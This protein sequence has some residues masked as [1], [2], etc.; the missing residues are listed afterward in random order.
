MSNGVNWPTDWR[1]SARTLQDTLQVE[2]ETISV[3]YPCISVQKVNQQFGKEN[4]SAWNWQQSW[5][6]FEP[7]RY[8]VKYITKYILLRLQ[9]TTC[10][11]AVL[12]LYNIGMLGQ[13]RSRFHLQLPAADDSLK[14]NLFDFFTPYKLAPAVSCNPAIIWM[15]SMSAGS[16]NFHIPKSTYQGKSIQHIYNKYSH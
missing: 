1:F 11:I 9:M 3:R 14:N 10:I 15:K 12:M 5:N 8:K 4:C 13:M 7:Y 6:W 2:R 16:K